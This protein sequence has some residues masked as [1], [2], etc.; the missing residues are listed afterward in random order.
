M[1]KQQQSI[2]IDEEI[3]NRVREECWKRTRLKRGDISAYVEEAIRLRL[4]ESSYTMLPNELGWR[5]VKRLRDT[6]DY[7][8]SAALERILPN[9]T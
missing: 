8:L 9:E 5:I 2:S 4:E 6:E 7:E 1:G 3:I